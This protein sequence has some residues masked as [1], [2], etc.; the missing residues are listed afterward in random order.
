VSSHFTQFLTASDHPLK[1]QYNLQRL[2]HL[3]SPRG[4]Y[5][6]THG[7]I[8]I[9]EREPWGEDRLQDTTDPLT[10]AFELSLLSW[11]QETVGVTP[12]S[13]VGTNAYFWEI[14]FEGQTVS[15]VVLGKMKNTATPPSSGVDWLLRVEE[16][17]PLKF[18]PLLETCF[19]EGPRV[20]RKME[21]G[22]IRTQFKSTDLR[23]D[24]PLAQSRWE[25]NAEAPEESSEQKPKVKK[26]WT[27]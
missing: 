3:F 2:R 20:K 4:I 22:K 24:S 14:D 17:E 7:G 10:D 8:T 6:L 1:R 21:E 27:F 5:S 15:L 16:E 25:P 13:C 12:L 9:I 26:W 23:P 18:I 19:Q 11:L